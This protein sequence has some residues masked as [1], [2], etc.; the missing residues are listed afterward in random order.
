MTQT[1]V[2]ERYRLLDRL[3][4]GGMGVVWLARDEVL[5]RDVAIKEVVLPPGLSP[6]ERDLVRLRT[7]REARAA[8]RLSHV[9]VVRIYDVVDGPAA[10]WI[11]MEYVPSRSLQQELSE[12]GP[13][14]SAR[15]AQI[16]LDV[17]AA[18]R[19]AHRAGVLHRDVKPG[20]VLLAEDG[21]VVLT[22]F[23][24]ATVSGEAAVTR[25][26]LVIG[27]PGFISPER[28]RGEP[29]QPESDLWSLGATLYAAVEGHGPFDRDSAI[30][31]LTAVGNEDPDPPQNAGPL[32]Q[33]FDG[34]LRKDP[35]ARMRDA[36]V[37]RRLRR[38][39]GAGRATRRPRFLARRSPGPAAALPAPRPPAEPQHPAVPQQPGEPEKPQRQTA[40]EP[41]PTPVEPERSASER[42]AP[43]T[44]AREK[45]APERPTTVEPEKATAP[46]E[47]TERQKATE[48]APPVV[49]R[50]RVLAGVPARRRLPALIGLLILMIMVPLAFVLLRNAPDRPPDGTQPPPAPR[51]T[52]PAPT[53]T[54]TPSVPSTTA[55]TASQQSPALPA[56][57]HVYR[58]RTGFSVGVPT[59]WEVSRRGTMV[60]FREPGGGRVLGIDQTDRPKPDP[61][62]DWESQESRRVRAGDFP[63]Y[64][65]VHIQKCDYFVACA[66]WEFTHASGGGRTRVNN[67]GVVV[68]P[69]KAYGF[70]WSTPES[71]WTES[72]DELETVFRTFQPVR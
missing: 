70:W 23:G 48:P 20:N 67:R 13:M 49:G 14:P 21:R 27:S 38:V 57:W 12:N 42:P 36:E 28:A 59:N 7:R 16:G 43:E 41:Q 29:G 65:R 31:T 22:D 11:V 44:P 61:V 34:L 45:P 5:G 40:V 51:T 71:Q 2:A 24:L 54:T 25:P 26:G 1:L 32:A 3:G 4:S 15:A 9:N 39:A 66:D 35:A 33:V 56:G 17:L 72:R 69:R 53:P 10:P 50:A 6:D 37:E 30:A 52:D 64:Q 60:Y 55:A 18:L 63:S 46:A 68:S 8:A 19:A 58:D 62:A 47:P